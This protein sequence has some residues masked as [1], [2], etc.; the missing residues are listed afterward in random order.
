MF[1]NDSIDVIYIYFIFIIDIFV[2]LLIEY[3]EK[4]CFVIYKLLT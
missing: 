2:K 1:V 4:W 3:Y